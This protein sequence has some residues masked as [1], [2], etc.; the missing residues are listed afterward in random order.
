MTT[1]YVNQGVAAEQKAVYSSADALAVGD[2]VNVD[3][4]QF[5]VE[6][7][8]K[9]NGTN[10][11]TQ[12]APSRDDAVQATGTRAFRMMKKKVAQADKSTEA[13]AAEA[14]ST[15]CVRWDAGLEYTAN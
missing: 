14:A 1:K 10:G 12:V 11:Q 15:E 9:A 7:A 13:I 6:D 5:K 8:D 4:N 3:G 2:I